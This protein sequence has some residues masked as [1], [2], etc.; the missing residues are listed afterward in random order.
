MRITLTQLF[1]SI[2]FACSLL[3]NDVS[4]QEVLEKTVTVKAEKIELHQLLQM[5]KEQTGASFIFSSKAIKAGRKLSVNSSNKKLSS[6]MDEYFTPLGIR[7]N[8]VDDQILLYASGQKNES[9]G[10]IGV[11]ELQAILAEQ[12]EKL[13][14]LVTDSIGAGLAGASILVKTN[15]KIGT[16]TDANGRFTLTVDELPVVLR[17][18]Y[19]GFQTREI[20]VSSATDQLVVRLQPATGNTMNDVV[21]VGYGTQRKR[22][23]TGAVS[24]ITGEQI[25]QYPIASA[26]QAL[27][28]R[29][30]G[31]Q[32]FQSSGAP[33]GAV[34]VRIRGVNSTAGGGA[35]QP[36]YVIDGIPLS[37]YNETAF[38]LG[39][40]NEGSSGAAQSNAQSPLNTISPADIESIEVLKDASAT[41]IYGARAANGVVLITTKTGKGATKIEVNSYSGIQSL[42]K[43]IPVTNARER[44]LIVAEH[45]RNNGTFGSDEIDVFAA[46]PFLHNDGTNWQ[47][48]VFQDAP[49]ANVNL[50]ISGA[51]NKVS[52]LVSGDYMKQDGIILNTFSNRASFRTN[53]DVKAT[54]WLKIGTRT[55]VSYQTDNTAKT[56]G[57]FG[58]LAYLL[59]LPP[60]MTVR[61][62]NGNFQGRYNSLVRGEIFGAAGFANL[63]TFNYVAELVEEERRAKRHRI[64]SNVFA[65]IDLAPGLSFK[66]VFGVDYLFGEL[67]NFAPIWQR[68][69]D[70]NPS[71]SVLESRPQ[72]MG[73]VA[74]QYLTYNKSF[75]NH[76]LNAVAGFSAQKNTDKFVSV[77]TTGST[78]NALNTL[79]NQPTYVGTPSGGEVNSSIVSQFLRLNYSYDGKYLFTGTLRRDGSSRFGPNFKYGYFPSAS[80]G[81]RI[82]EENFMKDISF[83]N[84]MKFR[85]SYG[86]TGN[87]NIGDFLYMGLVGGST[88]VY[89]NALTAAVAPFRF[90]NYDIQW[91][92]NKQM[93]VGVELSVMNSRLNIVAD[94]YVKRTDGLL[95]QYPISA[96]SGVGTSVIRNIGEIENRG[97]EFSVNALLVDKR[98]FKWSVDLNISTNRN[99]V[100]SLG[101]LPFI[102]G[103]SINRMNTFMNRTQ[104]GQPIGAFYILETN[105]MYTNFTE[106]AAAPLYRAGMNVPYFTPGD[107][108]LVDQNKDGIV[109]DN[110]RVFAGSPFPD[111]FG[112]VGTNVTYKQFTLNVLGSFQQGNRIF[113]YPHMIGSLG[114]V[115]M[116]REDFENRYQVRQPN[117]ETGTQILRVGSPITPIDKFL[118][119]GSFFRIRSISLSYEMPASV[120]KYIKLSRLR[121]Y[122]QANNFFVFTRY[123]GWD[124]E[125]SSFGSNVITNGIDFGAYPQAKSVIFGLNMAL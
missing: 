19:T 99:E 46:N 121:L 62:A 93:D 122:A 103:V 78:S 116:Y 13:S 72:T 23:I 41:A 74:D 15:S 5:L 4:G 49:M 102:N 119:D 28:G 85:A 98:D 96:I 109:E 14:G 79:G 88:A 56:D 81:W 87:Q 31:V 20:T 27:Q 42:R 80:V 113:N 95:A 67:R 61:D 26:D 22:E 92:K 51:S 18:S 115:N 30:P 73:W 64:N 77:S 50:S 84:D 24:R 68:G 90:D 44:M 123:K 39:F 38:A 86:I 55:A 58:G 40:G 9:L 45:R 12:R 94:Y 47:R 65:E 32:V 104:P 17:I 25:R 106:S 57:N 53:L 83:I 54:D 36:L 33:G 114:E 35:N 48:E 29:T 16:S 1:L 71:M 89:G 118:E 111:Y 3:A 69:I 108:R 60:T 21:V 59:Q 52:Y 105:G 6:F 125:V 10:T 120:L 2:L 107:Y 11:E 91:E 97:F 34:Q 110:D 43:E 7:Y 124:P 101:K 76:R 100:I 8:L 112:G 82:S 37:N 63:P 117:V 70:R 66:S 75:A